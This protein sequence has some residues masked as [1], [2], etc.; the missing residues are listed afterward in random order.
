MFQ[1]PLPDDKAEAIARLG[2]GI[3]DKI[4]VTFHGVPKDTYPHRS[5]LSYQLL[6]KVRL[7]L[8]RQGMPH[9]CCPLCCTP[10]QQ[11]SCAVASVNV[12]YAG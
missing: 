1:P 6:W 12:L 9:K 11:G 5:V 10:S 3:V 8:T 4:F 2:M 7:L